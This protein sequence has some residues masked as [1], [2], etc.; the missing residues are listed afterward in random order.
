MSKKKSNY[1][2]REASWLEFNQ[3]VLDRACLDSVPLLERLK[4]LAISASNLDEFMMVRFGGLSMVRGSGRDVTDI[5]GMDAA[6]QVEMIRERVGAMQ[7]SQMDCLSELEPRLKENGICRLNE[8]EL[9]DIQRDFLQG[10]FRNEFV[11]SVAPIG[12]EDS[13]EAPFFSGLK[14]HICVRLNVDA[15]RQLPGA[16]YEGDS[17]FVVIPLRRIMGRTWT[18]PSND[19]YSYIL[20]EDVVGLFLDE[21]FEG[22][23]IQDWTTFRLTRNGDV[24]LTEGDDDRGDLLAGMK[25]VL[26]ARKTSD[27]VRI[28]VDSDVSDEI[29]DFLQQTFQCDEQDFFRVEGP[30][31]LVG[32]FAIANWS[33]FKHLK[34]EPWPLSKFRSLALEK[35]FLHALPRATGS[36][37]TRINLT[38]RS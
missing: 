29:V 34:D 8:D 22:Q 18:V 25:E 36:S 2:S 27:V 1:I 7:Q 10:R 9:S 11:A 31:S 32:F 21:L 30:L 24:E 37:T 33:G 14:L 20:L 16:D 4:F 17:R 13:Q 23:E 5:T 38:I 6:A 3:R 26:E 19:S 28:E 12:I 15:K 35:I